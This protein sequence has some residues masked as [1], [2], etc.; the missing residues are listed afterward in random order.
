MVR[1]LDGE[2]GSLTYDVCLVLAQDLLVFLQDAV[3]FAIVLRVR[4]FQQALESH[5]P[6]VVVPEA[7]NQS[8][9]ALVRGLLISSAQA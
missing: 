3:Q 6:L 2:G 5:Y 7:C 4:L 9:E 1:R 8:L